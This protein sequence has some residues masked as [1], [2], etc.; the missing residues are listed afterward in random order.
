MRIEPQYPRITSKRPFLLLAAFLIV[1]ILLGDAVWHGRLPLIWSLAVLAGLT[2]L[3]VSA[4]RRVTSL[5]AISLLLTW[6]GV[7]V[8][9]VYRQ[10]IERTSTLGDCVTV[11]EEH[12]V[13]G[14]LLTEPEPKDAMGSF[15]R[16][17]S[18]LYR[19][20]LRVTG[21]RTG[22]GVHPASGT[23]VV[24][25]TRAGELDLAY[26][27]RVSL[28][29]TVQAPDP[30]RNPGGF[31]YRAYLE[32]K[33]IRWVLRVKARHTVERLGG[34]G[35]VVWKLIYAMRRRLDQ[36]IEYGRMSDES[37]AFL[38]AVLLGE[39]RGLNEE[40]EEAL[41]QTNTV[42]ILAISGLHVG[43]VALA[44]RRFLKACFLPPWA[45]SGLTIVAL[46][47]YAA[48]TGGHAS[49]VR[50]TVM[51]SAVLAAPLFRREADILNSLA[52]AAAAILLVRPLA[53]YAPGFQLSFIAAGTIV[54]LAPR[55]IEWAAER[56]HLRPEPGVE[57]TNVQAALKKSGIWA[58]QLLAVTFSA[59]IGVVLLTAWFFHRFAPLSFLPNVAVVT[60][61]GF[62]VPLGMLGAVLGQVSPLLSSGV[63]TMA[64]VLAEVLGRV[65]MF[66]STLPWAHFNVRAASALV[67]AA[68]YAVLV[69]AG[70]AHGASRTVRVALAAALAVVG[71]VAL[72]SPR[73][74]GSGVTEIVVLDVGKGDSIFVRTREGRRILIDG[75][76]V[77]GSDPGRWTIMPFLR[78]RGYNRL[79]AVVLTHWD[80]DHYGG[81]EHV[82]SQMP[83]GRFIIRGG[84]ET[85][86]AREVRRLMRLVEHHGIPIEH[87]EAGGRLTPPGDT[88]IVALWPDETTP[89]RASENNA[90]LV[91]HVGE[92]VSVL[93]AADIEDETE[94]Q[95][96]RA[97]PEALQAT[98]LKVPHQGSKRSSTEEFLDAVRPSLAI[99]TAD[100]YRMHLH[101]APETVER[102][103][104]RGITV[105]RTDDHGAITLRLDGDRFW[106]WTMLKPEAPAPR[107][108]T[109]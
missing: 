104:R 100:R 101:P 30:A 52:C 43:I 102:Y 35:S 36:G 56:W 72:W 70:F 6:L 29:C 32:G 99:I 92:D 51:M 77:V 24:T 81:L 37:R 84:P 68:Y 96:L 106:V 87:V 62:I 63:N 61:M 14:V 22:E 64:G 53:I 3:V 59:F 1:G 44:V 5:V 69:A 45:A 13:E 18:R 88:P 38:K 74:D 108:V 67:V 76:M 86:K 78:S 10:R 27:D 79:D 33:G 80:S 21:V 28:E 73:L 90:S 65:V 42:H 94:R 19:F 58:V 15:G 98:I 55:F 75:G 54:L 16:L 89:G 2:G 31:D 46:V 34:G 66:T 105:L 49:V 103:V 82:V 7:L 41:V 83:A 109:P 11:G 50:A 91:L 20:N 85:P 17:G 26:G 4:S 39:R 40:L 95:L 48:M 8:V 23:A 97:Q 107:P 9:N 60:L 71:G 93:L 57:T 12:R 47:F 25:A